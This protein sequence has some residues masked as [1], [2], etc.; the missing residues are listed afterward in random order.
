MRLVRSSPS[1]VCL[2]G[3]SPC[4]VDAGNSRYGAVH[5]LRDTLREG[6]AGRCKVWLPGLALPTPLKSGTVGWLLWQATL[7]FLFGSSV[8][9]RGPIIKA[10]D[11][12]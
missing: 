7:S 11:P 2:P 10:T 9:F 5:T 1:S 6:P 8:S 4:L 3:R 12:A